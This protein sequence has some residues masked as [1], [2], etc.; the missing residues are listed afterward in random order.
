MAL[1]KKHAALER[2][3]P[4]IAIVS[5]CANGEILKRKAPEFSPSSQTWI[6]D[7]PNKGLGVFTFG[8]YVGDLSPIHDSNIPFIAPSSSKVPHRLI[9]SL[10]WLAMQNQIRMQRVWDL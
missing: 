6:G 4:D 5:E 3:Q 2:L 10:F 8:S 9:C 1:D 7:N